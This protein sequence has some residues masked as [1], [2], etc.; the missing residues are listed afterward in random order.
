M[1]PPRP[2]W[3]PDPPLRPQRA[4]SEMA[5]RRLHRPRAAA[6]RRR[7]APSGWPQP[8]PRLQHAR[9]RA[10]RPPATAGGRARQEDRPRAARGRGRARSEG[11]CSGC[12]LGAGVAQR[13]ASA[14]E[15]LRL[16]E[17]P[18]HHQHTAL[19][20]GREKGG[21]EG[22]PTPLPLL[23]SHTN[24]MQQTAHAQLEQLR[25]PKQSVRMWQSWPR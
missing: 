13:V 16:G 23:I 21:E 24:S 3:P 22:S 8:Q 18:T 4:L 17:R 6:T 14:P 19:Q 20:T 7:W 11:W 25:P 5:L 2:R 10:A 15:H 12:R 9:R 1:A